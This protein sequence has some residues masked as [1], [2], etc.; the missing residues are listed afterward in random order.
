M[1][2]SYNLTKR[3]T[4]TEKFEKNFKMIIVSVKTIRYKLTVSGNNE[5]FQKT[6]IINA[7]NFISL[8][9]KPVN[10]LNYASTGH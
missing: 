10:T 6:G 1:K 5:I 2:L 4:K 8:Q 7:I 3:T 9:R